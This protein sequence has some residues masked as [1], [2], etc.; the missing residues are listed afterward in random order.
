[1]KKLMYLIVAGFLF[2]FTACGGG[3]N[4]EEAAVETAEEVAPAAAVR[5]LDPAPPPSTWLRTP[6][7]GLWLAGARSAVLRWPHRQLAATPL[8]PEPAAI[9]R[10]GALPARLGPVRWQRPQVQAVP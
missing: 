9:A 7:A 4:T 1:M 2:V 3:A 10:L 6:L 8:T 5:C